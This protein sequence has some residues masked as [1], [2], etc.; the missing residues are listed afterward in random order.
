M[1]IPYA[2]RA[3]HFHESGSDVLNRLLGCVVH[4]APLGLPALMIFIS[5]VNML[6]LN[7]KG[8]IVIFPEA[9]RLI[10]GATVA[11]FDKTGTLTGSQVSTV[12]FLPACMCAN[13]SVSRV[14]HDVAPA[15]T[16]LRQV[17]NVF[18]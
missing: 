2:I 14:L 12:L 10:S 7:H 8:I 4:A 17:H 1:T 3:A 6:R 11:C 13:G 5:S 15:G 9:L 18:A 16:R